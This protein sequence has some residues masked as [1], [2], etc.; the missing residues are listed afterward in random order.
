MHDGLNT[1]E[2]FQKAL[3]VPF[4]D[5]GIVRKCTIPLSLKGYGFLWKTLNPLGV[6]GDT[7]T[8]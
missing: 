8:I 7:E 2:I 5:R 6:A 4:R 1:N 3:V